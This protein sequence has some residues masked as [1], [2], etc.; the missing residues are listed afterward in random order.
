ML[1]RGPAIGARRWWYWPWHSLLIA[2]FPVLFLFAQNT[3]DQV[4]LEPL[5]TPLAICLIGAVVLLLVC[6]ALRRDW[7]RAGLIATAL[8]ALF[9]SY[10]HVWN[11]LDDAFLTQQWPLVVI[12]IIW[13]AI[14]V[15]VAWRGGPWVR[16]ATQVLNI[17]LA[18]LVLF[19]VGAIASYAVSTRLFPQSTGEIPQVAVGAAGRPDIYYIILDRYAGEDTLREIYDYD[20]SAFYE[21]LETRGFTI[22]HHAWAGYFKT[23]L[24]LV[25]SLSMDYLDPT[26][27]NQSNPDDF[28][29]IHAA[30]QH[31][32]AAPAT[33]KALG[34]E[35][36]HIGN[37]WEPSSRN[38]DADIIEKYSQYSEFAT[39]LAGT[40]MLVSLAP[41]SVPSADKDPESIDYPELARRSVIFG[42]DAVEDASTR[43]GPTYTFAHLTIPHPP[44]V[45]DTD[46]SMPTD[47]ERTDRTE[48]EEYIHQLEYANTRTLE[49][50]DTILANVGPNDPDPIIILQSDEGPWPPGFT[51]DQEHFQWLEASDEEIGWK[52]R[53]LNAYR[54]PGVD[55]PAQGFTDDIGPVNAFRILFNAY[56]GADLD[57]LP[58]KTYLSPDYDHMFDFVEHD[59]H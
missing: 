11:L 35:Y 25:S 13:A 30:L 55:L 50:L 37:W 56:F 46:G 2:A 23:A 43:P 44:Y 52:F 45:F 1:T 7:P 20:N 48:K 10:G 5:W 24:S 22:A 39:V 41:E 9:F 14:F 58:S 38:V 57:L 42:F 28:G 47:Q 18:A 21:A 19:N 29:A 40:T 17:A 31:R 3:A 36:V 34:Y 49:V 54:M 27:Y 4:T 16:T 33:L 51:A 8:L 15:S 12:W 32:L 26:R 6:Y 59:Q 53:I